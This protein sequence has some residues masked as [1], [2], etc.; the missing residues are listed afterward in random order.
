MTLKLPFKQMDVFTNTRFKGNPVAVVNCLNID[1]SEISDE[2]MQS[3]A[4]WTN[5]SETT[6][7]F[8]PTLRECTYK[9][10]IFTPA[11]ELPFA[12]HPTLGSCKAFLQ[13]TN[14][15]EI[16]NVIKQECG[17]G[18][19]NLT[20]DDGKISFVSSSNTFEPINDQI[21]EEIRCCLDTQF[22]DTP[23]LL[24]TGPEWIVCHVKDAQTCIDLK[25]DYQRLRN[26]TKKYGYTGV[27]VGG[28]KNNSNI[29]EKLSYEMRAFAPGIDVPED[30]VC[31]SGSIALIAYLQG[32]YKFQTPMNVDITQ[33]QCVSRKGEIYS[34]ISFDEK[35]IAIFSSGGSALC[36]ID[37]TINI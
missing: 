18:I 31:G 32:L 7:L 16:K 3:I 10:K 13:F 23:L 15:N 33:G 29:K 11:N 24:H 37:G 28:A 4:T 20:V 6:F 8:K 22:I 19:V 21:V 26:I 2:Q 5:L 36:I 17:V 12:G 35:G 9:L 25:P 30:P 14:G 27:I 34:S 1:E